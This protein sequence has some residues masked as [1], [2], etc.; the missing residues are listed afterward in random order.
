MEK[1]AARLRVAVERRCRGLVACRCSAE[2]R[3]GW[4]AVPHK[5]PRRAWGAGG[6][7]PSRKGPRGGERTTGHQR[8]LQ[9]VGHCG[10]AAVTMPPACV[11]R[12]GAWWRG[13]GGVRGGGLR[14]ESPSIT[15]M[16]Q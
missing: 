4:G 6:V 3:R 13:G 8:H 12:R 2:A 1:S 16:W 5:L 15:T 14:Y 11:R 10:G 9:L 7:R